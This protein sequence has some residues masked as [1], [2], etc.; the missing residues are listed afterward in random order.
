LNVVTCARYVTLGKATGLAKS[1][2]NR[3]KNHD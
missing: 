3:T 1:V 2:W